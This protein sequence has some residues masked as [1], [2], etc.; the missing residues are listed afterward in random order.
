V[1]ATAVG[2]DGQLAAEGLIP[3]SYNGT[4]RILITV[5]QPS[6]KTPGRVVLQGDV[7]L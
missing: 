2:A 5:Q 1:I 3:L 7:P 4:Y 6:A